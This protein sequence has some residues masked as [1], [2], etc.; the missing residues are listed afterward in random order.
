M[1]RAASGAAIAYADSDSQKFFEDAWLRGIPVEFYGRYDGS[2]AVDIHLLRWFLDRNSPALACRMVP[3]WLHAKVVWWVGV[4]AYI[5]SANLTQRAWMS[6]FEAGLFLSETELEHN[7]LM[8]EIAAFFDGLRDH[9]FMLTEEMYKAQ[10]ELQ[11]KRRQ[12]DNELHKLETD[13]NDQVDR[14]W[15]A[16]NPVIVR[17]S[18]GPGEHGYLRFKKEW[19]SA[20]QSMRTIAARASRADSRPDW[21]DEGVPAGVQADQLLHAFYYRLVREGNAQ[22][23][24][25]HF[26]SNADRP[27]AALIEVL[28]WWKASNFDPVD[29]SR[30]I[31]EWAPLIRQNFSESRVL[32]LTEEEWVATASRVHALRDHGTRME[33]SLLGLPSGT[34]LVAEERIELFARW[35]WLQRT[36]TGKTCLEQV[37]YL[38]WGPGDVTRRIWNCIHD[39]DWR[40]PHVRVSTLGEIVGWAR[41][42]EYPPRNQRSSKALRALGIDV[43]VY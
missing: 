18:S 2:V 5:G 20:L 11:Y 37:H 10:K 14:E 24:E 16:R 12:H 36:E 34:V 25:K 38:V 35:L 13:F 8:Q 32:T 1:G 15:A 19:D 6:N 41:P 3:K 33:N 7:G 4:G 43:E 40:L 9:S 30:T 39:A 21:I 23:Y 31:Y 29:E 17:S 28:S 26:S 42:N 22:P 27:E